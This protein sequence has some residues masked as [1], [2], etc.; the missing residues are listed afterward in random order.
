MRGGIKSQ[1]LL[2]T[3]RSRLCTCSFCCCLVLLFAWP[4]SLKQVKSKQHPNNFANIVWYRKLHPPK[5]AAV[6]SSSETTANWKKCVDGFCRLWRKS[7]R[8]TELKFITAA[9]LFVSQMHGEVC[10]HK[11]ENLFPELC[12]QLWVYIK[13]LQTYTLSCASW[14]ISAFHIYQR[15]GIRAFDCKSHVQST[16][17]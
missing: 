13:C 8:A 7:L 14:Q 5:A 2:I 4:C 17:Y 1:K 10:L 11:C 16:K 3:K 15:L 12:T 9:K 6:F